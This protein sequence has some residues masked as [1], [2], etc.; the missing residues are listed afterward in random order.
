MS[1]IGH[2][3]TAATHSSADIQRAAQL[4]NLPV[5]QFVLFAHCY[6]WA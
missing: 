2:N 6:R 5:S 1:A 4:G 3:L